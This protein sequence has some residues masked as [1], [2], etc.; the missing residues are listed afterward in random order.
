[1]K[2]L[3]K[4][5]HKFQQEVFPIHKNFFQDLAKGQNPEILF[6]TCSDSRINPHLVTSANPG[7]LFILRNAGN[8]IP[9]YSSVNTGETATI[10]FAVNELKVKDIIVCGHSF[11][12][13]VEAVLNLEKISNSSSLKNW[14]ETNIL[15]TLNL[16]N[17]NYQNLDKSS[18]MNILLQEHVLKQIE[19]LK[20]YPFINQAIENNKIALHAWV[21]KFESG[22]I[23]SYNTQDGQFE[24]IKHF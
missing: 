14:I 6:I 1:M 4:G 19:N 10:E 13:A 23:Y 7:D 11:C 18:L 16:V 21:Y 12:G 9:I 20:T 17:K 15:P 5:L 8:I 3:I 22:D 2:K 24:K